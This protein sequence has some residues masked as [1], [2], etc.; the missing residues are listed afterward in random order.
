[1]IAYAQ[2]GRKDMRI[3]IKKSARRLTLYNENN[4]PL[5]SRVIA[6]GRCPLG[7]KEREGDGRTP[8]GRYFVCL[9]KMGKYGL[10]LGVSYPNEQDARRMNA[11]EELTACIRESAAKGER[12]PWGSFLGGE[13][14]IH[15][16][17]T[18]SDWTA[19][20]IA[21]GD[22]DAQALYDMTLIGTE[23]EILP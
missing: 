21:L 2:E 4:E 11:P 12:P 6:L 23:I 10:S 18:D 14:Y 7:P 1:M 22:D 13:I 8:E 20:C 3:Q 19:G 9:K 17:G 16:G 5:F 15:G